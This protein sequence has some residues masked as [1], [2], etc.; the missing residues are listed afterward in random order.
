M[1]RIS[2]QEHKMVFNLTNKRVQHESIQPIHKCTDRRQ[3]H[4]ET[5]HTR[6]KP[7]SS[8]TSKSLLTNIMNL[9]H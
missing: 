2:E 9:W 7:I 6:S 1:V 8:L 4:S 5:S 3:C